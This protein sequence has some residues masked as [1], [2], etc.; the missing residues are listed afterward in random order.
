LLA[1]V[2][3]ALDVCAAKGLLGVELVVGMAEDADVLGIVVASERSRFH[4][5]EL[6]EAQRVTASTVG[7]YV[8]ALH[9]VT[10]EDAAT[11][12][13]PDPF[14]AGTRSAT[15]PARSFHRCEA[16]RLELR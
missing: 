16:L 3:L 12:G 8:R 6:E 9:S 2:T 10:F 1:Q 14:G 15:C 11:D 13:A 4:V 7:R 5:V